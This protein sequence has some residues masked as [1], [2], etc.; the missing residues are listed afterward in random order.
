[1]N[2]QTASFVTEVPLRVSVKDSQTL[3]KRFDAAR[4][5]YNACLDEALIRLRLVHQSRAYKKAV[6]LKKGK[7]RTSAFNDAY[8]SY[9]FN[10]FALHAYLN[11]FK[12]SW[13]SYHLDVNTMQTIATRAF[14]SVQ[15]YAF[16]KRGKPRFKAKRRIRSVEGKTN[17]QGITWRDNEVRW[18]KLRLSAMI[19]CSDEVVAHGLNSRIK[20]VRIVIREFGA[21]TR[22]FA[23]LVCEGSPYHKP[24]NAIGDSVVGLDIGPSTIAVVSDDSARLLRFCDELKDSQRKVR[25]A[26]RR[27]NRQRR[28]NN[29]VNYND[30]GTIKTGAKKW[31]K[32]NR[33]RRTQVCIAD[34]KRKQAA[35]R[36]SLHGRLANEVLALGADVRT[37]KLSYKSFQK[38]YGKSVSL[39]APGMFVSMLRRK[40]GS[41]GGTVNEFPTV[42][43]RL[44]QTCVCGRIAKKKLSQRWHR[45]EC[46]VEAQRDLFSAFLARCVTDNILNAGLAEKL[47]PRADCLLQAALSTIKTASSGPMPASF[48]ISR[49]QSRSL[50]DVQRISGEASDVVATA[51]AGARADESRCLSEPPGFSRGE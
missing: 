33:Q 27:L 6:K 7:G 46:G 4:Q 25:V 17:K 38:M 45:C 48:G 51:R 2:P 40:A 43:T 5:L 24:K 36:K 15:Q 29:P 34:A 20:S 41:A 23:Q 12:D 1:M 42:S 21:N 10:A 14:R 49:R 32:S 39:R 47:W 18:G 44:S 16:H 35:H 3:L 37:E 9:G 28:L 19:D 11:A 13:V 22:F 30:D 31:C 26:S 50:A 8:Q